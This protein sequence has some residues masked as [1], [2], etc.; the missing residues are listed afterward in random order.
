MNAEDFKLAVEKLRKQPNNVPPTSDRRRDEMTLELIYKA[1]VDASNVGRQEARFG[2]H[3]GALS[4]YVRDVLRENG[5][6]CLPIFQDTWA[7]NVLELAGYRVRWN[8]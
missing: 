7:P 3:F 5:C 6:E 2:P 1:M 8:P 4:T